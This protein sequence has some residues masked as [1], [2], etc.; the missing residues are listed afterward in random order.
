MWSG[1]VPVCATGQW[2]GLEEKTL[3]VRLETER[4]LTIQRAS[5]WIAHGSFGA[6]AKSFLVR[7]FP[8]SLLSWA[9]PCCSVKVGLLSFVR[10]SCADP[11]PSHSP[12]KTKKVPCAT[13]EQRFLWA[14]KIWVHKNPA[15]PLF[16]SKVC[17]CCLYCQCW[18]R[19]GKDGLWKEVGEKTP[20]QWQKEIGKPVRAHKTTTFWSLQSLWQQR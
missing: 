12:H 7:M 4:A 1:F 2:E 19:Q 3:T 13:W 6:C 15:A 11:S 14:L 5:T 18:T 17:L 10:C 8:W 20:L 16:I 9:K